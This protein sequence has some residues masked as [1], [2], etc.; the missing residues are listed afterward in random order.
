MLTLRVASTFT[1]EV[2][3]LFPKA[4]QVAQGE[5]A[6]HG[7][8]IDLAATRVRIGLAYPHYRWLPADVVGSTMVKAT[9]PPSA[10]ITMA[11][12]GTGFALKTLA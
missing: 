12:T 2:P 9:T 6:V 4:A 1:L 3:A 7:G 8:E 11:Y 5:T 10:M